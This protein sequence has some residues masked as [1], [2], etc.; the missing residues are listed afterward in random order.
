[1]DSISS[2]CFKQLPRHLLSSRLD[3]P[4]RPQPGAAR[5]WA[6]D[7]AP[8]KWHQNF[9]RFQTAQNAENIW[10]HD[11]GHLVTS[12]NEKQTMFSQ[13]S[14][15]GFH[16][17]FRCGVQ[18]GHCQPCRTHAASQVFLVPATASTFLP[19]GEVSKIRWIIQVSHEKI[20]CWW[21]IIKDYTT[22]F[23]GDCELTHSREKSVWNLDLT[24]EAYN[25]V[26]V[27]FKV[28]H[29]FVCFCGLGEQL[30]CIQHCTSLQKYFCPMGRERLKDLKETEW[31]FN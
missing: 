4:W 27:P 31:C 3:V 17:G 20:P 18:I 13:M 6:V 2:S 7:L 23:D 10:R 30:Y 28:D 12:Q 9:R 24:Y 26:Q 19:S 14:N 16:L 1:M 21:V 29:Q 11:L 15:L 25:Y 8:L 22:W 5:S